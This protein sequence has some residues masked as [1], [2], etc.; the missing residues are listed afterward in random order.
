LGRKGIA[1]GGFG[2][3]TWKKTLGMSI[4]KP[5]DETRGCL[6]VKRKSESKNWETGNQDETMRSLGPRR[7]GVIG[8]TLALRS[9]GQREQRRPAGLMTP[10]SRVLRPRFSRGGGFGG[11]MRE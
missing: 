9:T 7:D 10:V 8:D 4:V 3:E 6:E 11:K 2:G 5:K 1:V